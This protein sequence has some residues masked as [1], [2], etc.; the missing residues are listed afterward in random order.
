MKMRKDKQTKNVDEKLKEVRQMPKMKKKKI[1]PRLIVEI[2]EETR[3]RFKKKAIP[4]TMR[5]MILNWINDFLK[6]K[7]EK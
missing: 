1:M 5:S 7:K 4:N 3:D 6:G 2:E